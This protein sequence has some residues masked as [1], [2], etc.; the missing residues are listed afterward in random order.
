MHLA[1]A[2]PGRAL[3]R[4]LAGRPQPRTGR[5]GVV[6]FLLGAAIF[7]AGCDD[8]AAP[9]PAYGLADIEG[10]TTD[11]APAADECSPEQAPATAA[12]EVIAAAPDS[13]VV[14]AA[15]ERVEAPPVMSPTPEL[16]VYELSPIR[17]ARIVTDSAHDWGTATIGTE[18]RHTFVLRNSGDRPLSIVRAM[19]TLGCATVRFDRDI[20]AGGVG[21]VY[22]T[23]RTDRLKA[24]AMRL[25]IALETTDR[26][27]DAA[28]ILSGRIAERTGSTAAM[29]AAPI[30]QAHAALR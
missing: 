5:A 4:G 9:P 24:G 14:A 10:S 22:V 20:E 17:G 18:V 21:R 28:L 3:G 15:A 12:S 7:L 11:A 13:T 26:R 16:R 27:A 25:T 8:L 2:T 19:P 6:G 23:V 1:P 30:A 29:P